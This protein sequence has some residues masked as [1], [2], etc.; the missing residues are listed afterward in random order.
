MP[1]LFLILCK[2]FG[3]S[4]GSFPPPTPR[5]RHWYRRTFPLPTHPRLRH[6]HRRISLYSLTVRVYIE[7]SDGIG[8]CPKRVYVWARAKWG[9]AAPPHC[10]I[11]RRDAPI[12]TGRTETR[13]TASTGW[14]FR[15]RSA[16]ASST[17]GSGACF[18]LFT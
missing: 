13:W 1:G 5:L 15:V 4:G 18:W 8:R 2:F 3:V 6:W 7:W 16:A 9:I 17:C 11:A 14:R 10:R 12:P